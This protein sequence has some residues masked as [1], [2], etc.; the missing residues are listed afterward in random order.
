MA[1]TEFCIFDLTDLAFDPVVT[2]VKKVIAAI[3]KAEVGINGLLV[4]E[5]QDP[6]RDM[7]NDQLAFLA[8]AKTDY[9]EPNG[10]KISKEYRDKAQER[11]EKE[12]QKLKA[13]VAYEV[14]VGLKVVT[15]GRIK[16][17]KKD[18]T[19]LDTK[20]I[21]KVF[22]DAGVKIKPSPKASRLDFPTNAE[23][24]FDWLKTIRDLA[25]Y[26]RYYPAPHHPDNTRVDTLYAFIAYL[27]KEPENIAEYRNELTEELAKLL[28]KHATANAKRTGNKQDPLGQVIKDLISNAKSNVFNSDANRTKY[29]KHL[30]FKSPEITELYNTLQTAK[31]TGVNLEDPKYSEPAI[32]NI[33]KVFGNRDEA[34]TIYCHMAGIAGIDELEDGFDVKCSHCQKISE[35]DSIDHAKKVNQCV[36]CKATLYKAC[37]SCGELSPESEDRCTKSSC[38]FVFASATMFEKY[39]IAAE[40]A[41]REGNF[42]HAK[43]LLGKAKAANP[44]EKTRAVEL[45]SRISKEEAAYQK[46]INELRQLVNDRKFMAAS[47]ALSRTIAS[48]P[49]LNVV[50][51]EAQIKSSLEKA[52]STFEAAKKQPPSNCANICFDILDTCID[53]QPALDFLAVTPPAPVKNLTVALDKINCR[54]NVNWMRTGEKGITYRIVRKSGKDAPKNELDGDMLKDDFNGTAFRDETIPPGSWFSYG[55]FAKRKGVYSTVTSASALLLANVTDIRHEQNGTTVR[56]TW[57]LPKNCTGVKITRTHNGM[58]T[59]LTNNA[60]TSFEDRGLEYGESYSYTLHANYLGQ[61]PSAGVS[62]PITPSIIVNDFSISAKQLKGNKYNILWKIP[63]KGIDLRILVNKRVFRDVKSDAGSCEIELPLNGYHVVEVAAYSA[64]SWINS[65]NNIEI[66]TYAPLEIN[67]EATI[68]TEKPISGVAGSYKITIPIVLNGTIPGNV[69][70]FYYTVRIKA[71]TASSAPWATPDEIGSSSDIIRIDINKFRKDEK[72]IYNANTKGEDAFYITL[73]TEYSVDGKVVISDPHKRRIERPLEARI[74][75]KVNKPLFGKAKLSIEINPNRQIVRIPSL[76][77]RSSNGEHL[78]SHDDPRGELIF[79]N[80]DMELDSPMSVYKNEFEITSSITKNAKLFLFCVGA[81]KNE[82]F[83]AQW[84]SGF[85][86]KL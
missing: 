24:I 72:I 6:K 66:N 68:L 4:S 38:R 77:L 10:K 53:F 33:V 48:F 59:I 9:I 27:E 55:V 12:V 56:I 82:K 71:S 74:F 29:E 36:H 52:N 32:T 80:P 78:K 73:F 39:M 51:F 19:K 30:L 2:D 86:G 22:T 65:T 5:T 58:E 70:G 42:D 49:K 63:H 20:T 13:A 28:D 25:D 37:P 21:E 85:Q 7:M 64:G 15:E 83:I 43:D 84:A 54:A 47:Q 3:N 41:L 67:K 17:M 81:N 35:F 75:W 34:I 1:M 11:T 57:N 18:G 44:T 45:E 16:K 14:Q 50:T 46:P 8:K 26:R 69:T 60:Q 40:S 79:S 62:I 61:Q 76:L 23:K 31:R